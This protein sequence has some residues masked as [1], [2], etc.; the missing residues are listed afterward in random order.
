ME[1]VGMTYEAALAAAD[2]LGGRFGVFTAWSAPT[3]AK[4]FARREAAAAAREAEHKAIG[5]VKTTG[6]QMVDE[7]GRISFMFKVAGAINRDVHES[8]IYLNKAGEP[9]VD[10]VISAPTEYGY[11]T[12][13]DYAGVVGSA[14]EN[15]RPFHSHRTINLSRLVSWLDSGEEQNR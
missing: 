14:C 12:A 3:T 1:K 4:E 15:R 2:R 10:V 11:T 13:C 9:C 8:G 7:K 6:E 5:R